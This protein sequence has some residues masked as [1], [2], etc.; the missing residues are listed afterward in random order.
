MLL[1]F[2]QDR[3]LLFI[4]IRMGMMFLKVALSFANSVS[5]SLP[6]DTFPVWDSLMVILGS[7]ACLHGN[8]SF[9]FIY[10]RK[11]LVNRACKC[12]FDAMG[13]SKADPG[14]LGPCDTSHANIA[15]GSLTSDALP[16]A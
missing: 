9:L 7:F 13:E 10:L 2:V 8:T 6:I 11:H 15:R 12:G 3:V 4:S 5:L 14:S 16:Q 1:Y